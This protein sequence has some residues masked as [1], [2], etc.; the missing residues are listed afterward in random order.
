MAKL[1]PKTKKAVAACVRA[2]K[3]SPKR[4][5]KQAVFV[6][7]VDVEYAGELSSAPEN[8]VVV[9]VASTQDRAVEIMEKAMADPRSYGPQ[10]TEAPY[11][12][13]Q[14]DLNTYY[15]AD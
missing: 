14:F 3:K 8:R 12:I 4:N 11:R 6:V 15:S 7:T 1:N 10:K 13:E 5:P 9:G 2:A